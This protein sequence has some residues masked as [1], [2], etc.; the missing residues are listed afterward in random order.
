MNIGEWITSVENHFNQT[1]LDFSIQN[2]VEPTYPKQLVQHILSDAQYVALHQGVDKSESFKAYNELIREVS[3]SFPSLACILL[4]Q[5]VNGVLPLSLFGTTEQKQ[6]YLEKAVSGEWMGALAHSEKGGSHFDYIEAT[7]EKVD[8]GWKLNGVKPTVSNAEVADYFIV[9]AKTAEEQYGLFIVERSTAGLTIQSPID[10]V[11]MSALY[12]NSIKLENVVIPAANLL[13]DEFNAEDQYNQLQQHLK[14]AVVSL[15]LGLVH[16]V[17]AV[18][19]QNLSVD[20][21]IGLPTD[22][23]SVV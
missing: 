15:A 1:L 14:V 22:R 3:K 21:N 9:T 11:G 16:E 7:A 23:K 17:L 18:G 19:K 10:K 2:E 5:T 6:A 12:V 8:E 4:T 13:G 20:R